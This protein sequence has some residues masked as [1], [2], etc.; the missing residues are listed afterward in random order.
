MSE[1]IIS[2][3]VLSIKN[4]LLDTIIKKNKMDIWGKVRLQLEVN[5]DSI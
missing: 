3:F 5:L 2:T 1:V 4:E